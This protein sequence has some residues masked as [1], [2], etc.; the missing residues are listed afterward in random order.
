VLCVAGEC[1]KDEHMKDNS[2]HI[3]IQETTG[4]CWTIVNSVC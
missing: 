4:M 3:S 1:W 2:Q